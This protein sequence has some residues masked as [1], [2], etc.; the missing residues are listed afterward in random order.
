MQVPQVEAVGREA[1]P[2]LL[3]PAHP[4]LRDPGGRRQLA[5]RLVLQGEVER[6]AQLHFEHPGSR[7]LLEGL[8]EEADGRV[9]VALA[10]AQQPQRD[11]RVGRHP[12]GGAR[13]RGRARLL[14]P[15]A[16]G[17]EVTGHH[18]G[19][20][21]GHH[22]PDLVRG[23]RV[24]RDRLLDRFRRHPQRLGPR[25]RRRALQHVER[26]PLAD[27]AAQLGVGVAGRPGQRLA[28]PPQQVHRPGHVARGASRGGRGQAEPA[29][30]H[31]GD[32]GRVVHPVP[33]RQRLV[34]VAVR[35]G[36][37]AEPACLVPRADRRGERPRH[38]VAGQ[39]V[40]RQLG[41]GPRHVRQ[42][43]RE[44]AVEP[45]P[46]A[47]QQVVVD[48]LAQQRVAEG[49]A[50]GG[51]R[52]Q[53]LV[54][55]RVPDRVVVGGPGQPRGGP[56]EGV[57]GPPAGHRGRPQ[58]LLGGI[59]HP[60]HPGQQQRRQARG[61]G[62]LAGGRPPE[63]PGRGRQRRQQLLGVVGVP[64]GAGDDP[65]DGGGGQPPGRGVEGG[66][67]LGQRGPGERAELDRLH[68]RE[69]DQVGHQ[70]AERVTTVEVVGAV[71]ADH[72][73]TFAV[74]HPQQEGEQVAGG[75]VGP[76]QVLQHQQDR[77][78]GGQLG[79][80]AEHGPEHLLAGQPARVPLGA[81]A[82]AAV[83]QQPGEHRTV[84]DRGLDLRRGGADGVGE[85]EVGH[86]VA[87][88][89][90]LAA[91]H[92]EALGRRQP[93]HLGHQ[94][95]LADPGVTADQRG[96]GVAG[97]GV[98]EHRAEPGQFAV[99]AYQGRHTSDYPCPGTLFRIISAGGGAHG[100]TAH[101]TDSR[102]R[103]RRRS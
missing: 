33:Q 68:R 89:R 21:V 40:V 23:R 9:R 15:G 94:P 50:V 82:V 51:V 37:G 1:Q 54:G 95:G 90:A 73:H 34:V 19:R 43:G 97:G 44:P 24:G 46:L 45:G 81:E 85:R 42:Q 48:R 49:V 76:V 7:G 25:V 16:R 88:L 70:R 61:E 65:V 52:H 84:L 91:E 14:G 47:R 72:R 2:L 67:Q 93:G 87:D 96:D 64:L 22:R 80:Q 66:Q 55:H 56:D 78:P 101:W 36:R 12:A 5:R 28:D 86:A 83:G 103:A 29:A 77:G 79:Q 18:Q 32:H 31:P 27:P 69:P 92:G 99:T 13:V 38:V 58:H 74:Q 11:Q 62:R 35:L 26:Q 100:A 30:A 8:G 71:G 102:S 10:G 60:F 4:L 3:R 20:R 75:G 39:A 6:G 17:R 59:R 63:S 53:Q 98:V 41:G 57:I